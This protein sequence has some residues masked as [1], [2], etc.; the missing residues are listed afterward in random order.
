MSRILSAK[1]RDAGDG[2]LM[3]WCPG[4]KSR[5][6]INVTKPNGNGAIWDWNRDPESPTFWPSINI[7]G[8]CHYFITDG[9]IQFCGDS[10]HSLA[11]Q[12]MPLPDF[13]EHLKP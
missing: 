4:C 3:H 5:H 11:G 13:P 12:I 8:R 1:L 10:A 7:V 6:L 9:N 2:M